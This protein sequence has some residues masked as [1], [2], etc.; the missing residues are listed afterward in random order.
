M[1]L[2]PRALIVGVY[3]AVPPTTA[4]PAVT[5]EKINRIWAEVAPSHGYR[6]LQ[7]S[8][9]GSAAQFFGKTGDDGVSIQLPVIQVRTAIEL[10]PE[11]AADSAYAILKSIANHLG[12]TEFLN[13][14]IKHV[15]HAPVVS[16]DARSFVQLRLL[17]KDESSVDRLLRGGDYWMGL[18]FG[19]NAPDGS[20]YVLTIEP[21]LADNQA[22]FVD[23]DAQFL[24]V[25]TLDAVRERAREANNYAQSAV[26]GYLDSTGTP[27]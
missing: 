18:K 5:E 17:G 22:V 13:L 9:D 16:R 8:P 11:Q 14:G 24:G 23:L 2:I 27:L 7:I 15:Y 1:E 21:W 25:A 3:A 6:Q 26:K 10:T 4:A 20:I 12:L 19:L